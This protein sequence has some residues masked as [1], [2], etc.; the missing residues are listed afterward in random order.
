MVAEARK[1]RDHEKEAWS[2]QG[3]VIPNQDAA[4]ASNYI[5]A[6]YEQL[7]KIPVRTSCYA[8]LSARDKSKMP[9][10]INTIGLSPDVA[11]RLI[12][13]IELPDDAAKI[14]K[15]YTYEKR[16][17]GYGNKYDLSMKE[18]Y[19]VKDDK[20]VM[21]SIQSVK[22]GRDLSGMIT[23]VNLILR[24]KNVSDIYTVPLLPAQEDVKV[25]EYQTIFM[26]EE[27]K[28]RNLTKVSSKVIFVPVYKG[29][30]TIF[31]TISR[32][33]KAGMKNDVSSQIT[34]ESAN[35]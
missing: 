27:M 3:V 16:L 20:P 35:A 34:K 10:H 14:L 28:Q 7:T 9:W 31:E 23:N 5:L 32:N 18:T 21:L 2:K 26:P 12:A 13:E 8:M 19:S 11:N 1:F 17:L 25:V 24:G 15:S 4:A 29:T 6:L 30:K 33:L 22:I